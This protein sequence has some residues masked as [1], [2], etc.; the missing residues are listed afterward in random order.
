M[1]T[2]TCHARSY[3]A[4][5]AWEPIDA[6]DVLGHLGPE[7]CSERSGT[8]HLGPHRGLSLLQEKGGAAAAKPQRKA[9]E[10]RQALAMDALAGKGPLLEIQEI[11]QSFQLPGVD[12]AQQ[13]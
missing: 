6:L 9:I 13:P 11:G 1:K 12:L 8:W 3:C 2:C 4:A 10:T 7:L 5:K